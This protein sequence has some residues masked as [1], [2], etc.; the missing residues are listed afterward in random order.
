MN[1]TLRIG[2][3]GP[4]VVILQT[5]LNKALPAARPPLVPDGAF[6]PATRNR[7]IE[8]QRLRKLTP[9]GVVG[10]NTWAALGS[11]AVGGQI[12]RAHV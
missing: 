12:G 4:A 6:G 11:A 7:V 5:A 3:R 2:A 1:P 8:F 9:D 10:A